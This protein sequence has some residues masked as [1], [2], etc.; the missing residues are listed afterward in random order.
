[1]HHA[2]H[3]AIC[4][5]VLTL[6]ACT[7]NSL[8]PPPAPQ[9]DL[10][11]VVTLVDRRPVL[12]APAASARALARARQRAAFE[13][14]LTD[15]GRALEWIA[16]RSD[17]LPGGPCPVSIDREIVRSWPTDQAWALGIIRRESRCGPSAQNGQSSAAGLM[18]IVRGSWA[19]RIN[20][21]A[22][23]TARRASLV[24]ECPWERRYDARCN[25]M[26]GRLLFDVAGRSP[27]RL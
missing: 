1:M 6:T 21:P 12:P 10:R 25:L 3:L 20:V 8:T 14:F 24:R 5:T 26:A 4:L 11:A 18:Q 15:W 13:Q 7:T 16:A 9:R 23:M 27:W 17:P 2:R 19:D 22:S